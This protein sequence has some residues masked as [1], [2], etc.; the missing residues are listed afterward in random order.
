MEVYRI[1]DKKK[2]KET[3]RYSSYLFSIKKN[4]KMDITPSKDQ[5]KTGVNNN[6]SILVGEKINV[7][8]IKEI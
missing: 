4:L 2:A 5:T 8:Y 6:N 7:K 1:H 3:T